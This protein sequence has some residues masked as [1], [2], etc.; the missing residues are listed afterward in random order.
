MVHRKYPLKLILRAHGPAELVN[1][2]DQTLWASDADDDFREEFNDEFLREEDVEDILDYLFDA[3]LIS[4]NEMDNLSSDRWP[5]EI[6]TLESS[7]DEDEL[8]DE[9]E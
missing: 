8:E 4:I 7:V 5:V 6:E 1:S 3:E 2:D 9:D